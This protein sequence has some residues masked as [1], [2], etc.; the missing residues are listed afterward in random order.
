[1]KNRDITIDTSFDATDLWEYLLRLEKR[2]K[3]F[4]LYTNDKMFIVDKELQSVALMGV[5]I[6][7]EYIRIRIRVDVVKEHNI[8][9]HIKINN[10]IYKLDYIITLFSLL[11]DMII[12]D[13]TKISL[14]YVDYKDKVCE[15]NQL[16]YNTINIRY[17]IKN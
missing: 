3:D 11:D 1:M 14:W 12:I 5:F 9:L 13:N 15:K 10:K 16:T 2:H 7:V 6:N 8:D 17:R 4:V